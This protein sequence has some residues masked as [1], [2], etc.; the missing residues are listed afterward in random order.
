VDL[1]WGAVTQQYDGY[2]I[3]WIVGETS[4]LKLFSAL[5]EKDATCPIVVLT[6]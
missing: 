6:A 4:T 3:D 2:V 1:L 5:R